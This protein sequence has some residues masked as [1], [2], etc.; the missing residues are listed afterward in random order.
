M[1]GCISCLDPTSV[2][3][4][5]AF[6]ELNRGCGNCDVEVDGAGD[7]RDD[8]FR[9]DHPGVDGGD[10]RAGDDVPSRPIPDA[11]AGQGGVEHHHS[12]IVGREAQG[13]PT[14]SRQ[15]RTG[16][17][18]TGSSERPLGGVVEVGLTAHAAK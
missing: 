4:A 7:C 9:I 16:E 15:T 13:R 11:Q 14:S 1:R 5:R 8:T 2:A 17:P 10:R 3:S 12:L 18:V 6:D